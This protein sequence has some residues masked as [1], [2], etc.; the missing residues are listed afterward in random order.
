MLRTVLVGAVVALIATNVARA[1]TKAAIELF[2]SQGCSSCPPADKL[3]GELA[4]NPSLVVMS[5][6][7][8]YWDYLGWKDTLALKGHA[9]RQH[10]YSKVR[11][12]REVY[13]PQVVVN[14]LMHV[15]GSDRSAIEQAV[16]ITRRESNAM[17]LNIGVTRTGDALVVEV[18]EGKELQVN[19]EVWLLPIST[20]VP[21]AIERGENRGKTITYNNVVRRW[22]KLGEWKGNAEVFTI[23]IK[24]VLAAEIDSVAVLV[25][26][27][28]AGAPGA[29]LG[30]AIVSVR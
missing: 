7:V 18:P 25:Q 3:M 19:A 9:K 29:V 22:V 13:T 12:D 14:G 6:A 10:A 24:D 8:D 17:R 21:V 4:L 30:A 26:N 20:K 28:G 5:L 23:A 1:E 11:G 2:T 16:E 27:G 15:A